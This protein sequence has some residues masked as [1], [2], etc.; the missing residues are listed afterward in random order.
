MLI[1]LLFYIFMYVLYVLGNAC[2]DS[3]NGCVGWIIYLIAIAILVYVFKAQP[4]WIYTRLMNHK[5]FGYVLDC[6][7]GLILIGT[8]AATNDTTDKTDGQK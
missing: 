3:K 6:I 2:I 7:F 1:V 8:M 5:V 4:A